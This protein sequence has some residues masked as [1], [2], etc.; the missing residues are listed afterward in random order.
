MQDWQ[1]RLVAQVASRVDLFLAGGIDA[2][3][4]LADSEGLMDAANLRG[5]D[6]WAEF[7]V[8]WAALDGQ[9]ELQTEPWA[10]A[11]LASDEALRSAA[12]ALRGW[13]TSASSASDERSRPSS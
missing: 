10:P 8:R 7:Y 11:G 9:S 6:E 12:V 1:R 13:A 2:R 4:L 3:K 5:S